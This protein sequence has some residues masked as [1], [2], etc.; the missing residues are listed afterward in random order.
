[1]TEPTPV[2]TTKPRFWARWKKRILP[3]CGLLVAVG[4]FALVGFFY[5]KN[6]DFFKQDNIAKFGYAGVFFVSVILNATIIIPISNM[7]VILAMGAI[8][9]MP[10]LVGLIG[11]IGAVIGE[12]TGYIAGRSGRNLL[13]GNKVYV[14]VE[15]WVK[16]RGWIA[17]FFLSAFPFF[18]DLVGIIA[19]ALRMPLWEFALP[20]FAG[21]TITYT[22][23]AYLGAYGIQLFP[24][25]N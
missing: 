22:I 13:A 23:V 17:I 14:R 8:L 11:G 20:T 5:F 25:F 15:K 18:F 16:K 12:M 24:W 1:M 10:W 21:R 3:I 6:P 7:T 19:G 9:P 2:I 4:I